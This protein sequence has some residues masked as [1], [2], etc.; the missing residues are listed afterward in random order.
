MNT[1]KEIY[2]NGL[3]DLVS[4]A[5]ERQEAYLRQFL[6][7]PLDGIALA[8][9]LHGARPAVHFS[10]NRGVKAAVAGEYFR[11]C[12]VTSPDSCCFLFQA[13]CLATMASMITAS[14]SANSERL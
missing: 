12:H 5:L 11:F 1:V 10:L 14:R 4:N 7:H 8:V 2:P 13:S 6:R 3:G 9:D